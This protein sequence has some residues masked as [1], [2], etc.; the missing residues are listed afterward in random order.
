MQP[1]TFLT[2]L[3][4]ATACTAQVFFGGR[5]E[6]L[7]FV[8]EHSNCTGDTCVDIEVVYHSGHPSTLKVKL[9]H[10]ALDTLNESG[11]V[12]PDVNRLTNYSIR[13]R[14]NRTSLDVYVDSVTN[15]TA[16][17]VEFSKCLFSTHPDGTTP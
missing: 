7:L 15:L 9:V 10:S 11:S 5:P 14:G 16:Q 6:I 3:L 4:H 13:V 2:F 8:P 12:L 1:F 17:N